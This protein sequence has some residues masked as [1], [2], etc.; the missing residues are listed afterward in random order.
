VVLRSS[1]QV[2]LPSAARPCWHPSTHQAG[3][4]TGEL[5][6]FFLLV[7]ND[8][9]LWLQVGRALM[10]QGEC[11]CCLHPA[12]QPNLNKLFHVHNGLRVL[13]C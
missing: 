5:A 3:E 12:G 9:A 1:T 11:Q 7:G 4:G 13:L 6:Y 10:L 2:A 8:G